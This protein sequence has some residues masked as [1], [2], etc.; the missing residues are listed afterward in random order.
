MLHEIVTFFFWWCR[1]ALLGGGAVP[2]SELQVGQSVNGT[3]DTMALNQDNDTDVAAAGEGSGESL[4]V[5]GD[6]AAGKHRPGSLLNHFKAAGVDE[7]ISSGH[8][9]EHTEKQVA[10]RQS[11]PAALGLASAVRAVALVA[12]GEAAVTAMAAARDDGDVVEMRYNGLDIVFVL[13]L[14]HVSGISH[15]YVTLAH[16]V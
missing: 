2:N 12:G 16:A 5:E 7:R 9:A 13:F 4:S 11:A 6:P 15:P 14:D 3:H 10:S 1:R 8:D